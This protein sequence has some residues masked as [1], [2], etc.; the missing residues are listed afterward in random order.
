[1]LILWHFAGRCIDSELT[2]DWRFFDMLPTQENLKP[3]NAT[4]LLASFLT[5]FLIGGTAGLASRAVFFPLCNPTNIIKANQHRQG[6]TGHL[7][8]N[9][10]TLWRGATKG[11]RA[12]FFTLV[13]LHHPL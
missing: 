12:R 3:N 5:D 11:A 6:R 10:L 13:S 8:T 1:M 2:A 7:Q 9:F 4:H